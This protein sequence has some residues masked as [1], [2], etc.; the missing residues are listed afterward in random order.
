MYVCENGCAHACAFT[1]VCAGRIYT[2]TFVHVC[3][4]WRSEVTF[5]TRCNTLHCI[6]LQH[7]AK[8]CN[9]LQHTAS[10]SNT[11][12]YTAT[13]C[14]T[15]TQ[16]NTLQHTEPH[17]NTLQ[18]TAKHCNARCNTLQYTAAHCN[19]LQYTLQHT[20]THYR[21]RR[22][23]RGESLGG[24]RCLRTCSETTYMFFYTCHDSFIHV[25]CH[26]SFLHVSFICVTHS[27]V[28][29]SHA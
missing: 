27:H 14:N 29:H 13:H 17:W 20:A 2:W 16:C 4:R 21:W 8:R 15:L 19:A 26:D 9:T 10:H 18:H 5:T 23:S 12:Q 28:S 3:N 24:S 1:C 11:L 25:S 22:S 6:T 7:V